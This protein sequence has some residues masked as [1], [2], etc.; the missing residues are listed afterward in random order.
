MDGIKPQ[1]FILEVP[2][3]AESGVY[4]PLTG[5]V[6][7]THYNRINYS[8]FDISLFRLKLGNYQK[9]ID[10]GKLS[11]RIFVYHREF[12]NDPERSNDQYELFFEFD[13]EQGCYVC[14]D[15]ICYP[16]Y[17]YDYEFYN[18]VYQYMIYNNVNV[19][20]SL[21]FEYYYNKSYHDYYS[22]KATAENP[23]T[24][25]TSNCIIYYDYQPE[26]EEE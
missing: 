14:K 19:D 17:H 13:S 26:E 10:I 22:L 4:Y 1:Y 5:P 18:G 9:Q 21:Q 23:K 12:G 6:Y 24:P 3:I 20:I 16:A 8:D 2:G 15:F 11:V 7:Y 25:P